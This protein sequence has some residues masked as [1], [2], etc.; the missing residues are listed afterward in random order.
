MVCLHALHTSLLARNS[1]DSNTSY[2]ASWFDKSS[3][4]PARWF[5]IHPIVISA[6]VQNLYENLVYMAPLKEEEEEK[7]RD[8]NTQSHLRKKLKKN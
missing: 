2:S 5:A 4:N 8:P 6:W 3:S 7:L 1:R